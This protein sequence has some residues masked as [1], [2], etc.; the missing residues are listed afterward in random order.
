MADVTRIPKLQGLD[1]FHDWKSSM[2]DALLLGNTW[3]VVHEG[4]SQEQSDD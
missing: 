4:G 1:N 2:R 3:D